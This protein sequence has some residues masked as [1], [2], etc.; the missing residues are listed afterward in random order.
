MQT[1][2]RAARAYEAATSHRSIREQ[3]ADVFRRVSGVL[4]AAST[5]GRLP[6]VRALADNR[7]LWIA[8]AD[9]VRDS[10]NGLP[11]PLRA[12]IIS[13]AAN[14]EYEMDQASPNLEFLA[15]INDHL[16]AGLSGTP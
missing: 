2:Q 13:L 1:M 10:R 4:R 6:Q 14:V 3:E 8:V 12:G 15:N 16:A 9:L 7:R 11:D 5:A